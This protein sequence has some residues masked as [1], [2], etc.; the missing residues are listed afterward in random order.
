[1]D[2]SPITAHQTYPSDKCTQ[3]IPPWRAFLLFKIHHTDVVTPLQEPA[4]P[5]ASCIDRVFFNSCLRLDFSV[6]FPFHLIH[7]G[8]SFLMHCTVRADHVVISDKCD[9]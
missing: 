8:R 2:M 7:N 5:H 9:P 6:N 1:M 4:R 3:Q